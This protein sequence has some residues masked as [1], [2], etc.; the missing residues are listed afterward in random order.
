MK[1]KGRLYLS[2]P[3]ASE[4]GRITKYYKNFEDIQYLKNSEF[5]DDHIFQYNKEE[6]LKILEESGFKIIKF[7]YSPGVINRHFNLML[8]RK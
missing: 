1:P 3:D 8:E 7:V 5:I 6:L 2:T 4:W